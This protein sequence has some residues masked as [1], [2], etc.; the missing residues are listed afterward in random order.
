MKQ[1]SRNRS[2]EMFLLLFI[3]LASVHT[4]IAIPAIP[5][6][7]D[8]TV[9]VNGELASDG[10]VISVEVDGT[11]V[12][13]YVVASSGQ[14]MLTIPGEGED[15]GKEILFFVDGKK[16]ATTEEWESGKY[17]SI[18]IEIT[19]SD[20]SSDSDSGTSSSSSSSSSFSTV[21][22]VDQSEDVVD[23]VD[24]EIQE[25][26]DVVDDEVE[27][28]AEYEES[29]DSESNEED[30]STSSQDLPGFTS[31]IAF[32]GIIAGFWGHNWKKR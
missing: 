15:A 19:T 5:M 8:G 28:S 17:I 30:S 26:S 9:Y 7:V 21:Q 2:F 29:D 22:E 20:T 11:V 27:P 3:L 18:D 14:Y 32:I 1:I 13:E 4:A 10:T 23:E 12:E 16:A 6:S 31:V 24:G 25:E